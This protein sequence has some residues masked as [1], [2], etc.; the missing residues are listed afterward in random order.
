MPYASYLAVLK[1]IEKR[2][3]ASAQVPVKVE[4]ELVDPSDK[5]SPKPK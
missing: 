4:K 2:R 1:M 5:M 3:K